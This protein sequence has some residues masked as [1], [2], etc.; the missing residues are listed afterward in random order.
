MSRVRFLPAAV[1]L[2]LAPLAVCA[3]TVSPGRVEYA[4]GLA[5]ERVVKLYGASVGR[6]KGYG[7]G[8]IVSSDGY[9]VTALSSLLESE[10]PRVVLPDGRRLAAAVVAR[11]EVRQLALLKVEATDLPHF[12]L[13]TS[14]HLTGGDW[15]IAAANPFKVADGPEPV[16]V[17]IGVLSGRARLD[18]RRRMQEIPYDGPVLLTDVIVSSPG[19]AGGALI[20]LDGRL[21][22]VI[23]KEVQSRLTNTWLNYAMPV[24][25]VAEFVMQAR[26]PAAARASSDSPPQP[27]AGIEPAQV[28]L[29]LFDVAGRESPAYVE[30]VR[31][32]SPAA[33]A[34]IR[35]NDLILSLNGQPVATC[36]D[37]TRLLAGIPPTVRLELTLKRGEQVIF[38]E[39][40]VEPAE[41]RP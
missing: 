40:T 32:N 35:P 39:L 8:V 4:V 30:R 6:V 18:A 23:G 28:G 2:L 38:A 37:F 33:R 34:D 36:D 9:I 26:E 13:G 17:A 24:E 3:Q 21:V 10:V 20:D 41:A 16:S 7:S 14:Q 11:D 22:G 29:R 27:P 15:V 25:Q 19:S 12:E 31:A 1:A 5:T